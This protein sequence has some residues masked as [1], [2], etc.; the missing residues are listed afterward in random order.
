MSARKPKR[1]AKAQPV[2]SSSVHDEWP[3]SLSPIQRIEDINNMEIAAI[4][5]ELRC[6]AELLSAASGHEDNVRLC[7]VSQMLS[8]L[9]KRLQNA[10]DQIETLSSSGRVQ[11]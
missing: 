7:D 3:N 11:S 4:S 9:Q 1:Q 6:F 5:D 8:S 10:K 2:P